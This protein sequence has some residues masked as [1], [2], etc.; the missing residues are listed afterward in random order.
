MIHNSQNY[1]FTLLKEKARLLKKSVKT[2]SGDIQEGLQK[3]YDALNE[4]LE[5]VEKPSFDPEFFHKD[6]PK[7]EVYN[8]NLKS[9]MDEIANLRSEVRE[10][11]DLELATFNSSLIAADSLLSEIS[12]LSSDIIDLRLT[13]NMELGEVIVG[14]DNFF[15]SSKIDDALPSA[16]T[17][18]QLIPGGGAIGLQRELVQSI[19]PESVKIELIER[20]RIIPGAG[21]EYEGL[22]YAPM[23]EQRPEGGS[24]HIR[25]FND[26]SQ[27]DKALKINTDNSID[28]EQGFKYVEVGANEDALRDERADLYDGES[29][30]FWEIEWAG[31]E[32]LERDYTIIKLPK[33]TARNVREAKQYLQ[34]LIGPFITETENDVREKIYKAKPDKKAVPIHNKGKLK[35]AITVNLSKDQPINTL[36]LN[37]MRFSSMA[38]IRIESIQF[39][40]TGSEQFSEVPDWDQLGT[41]KTLTKLSNSQ[42]TAAQEDALGDPGKASYRGTGA[43]SFPTIIGDKLRIIVSVDT[44]YPVRYQRKHVLLKNTVDTLEKKQ[45]KIG[46]H[47]STKRKK[48]SYEL[49]MVAK[50]SYI[51]TI[52]VELG[53]EPLESFASTDPISLKTGGESGGS[54]GGGLLGGFFGGA[55][56]GLFGSLFDFLGDIA[57]S[58]GLYSKTHEFEVNQTG[59]EPV[60]EWLQTYEDRARYAVGIRDINLGDYV[61]AD[62]SEFVSTV[63]SSPKEVSKVML[64]ADTFFPSSLRR[65]AANIKYYIKPE[66]N[67]YDIWH[68]INPSSAPTAYDEDGDVVPKII[69]FNIRSSESDSFEKRFIT[70]PEPVKAV[71]VKGMI[72]TTNNDFSPL[73]RSY[74]IIMWPKGGL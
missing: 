15:D 63:Y 16:S 17:L 26:S 43:F 4:F 45:K 22:Y 24:W 64:Y 19:P 7:S 10:V 62:A 52:L 55:I 57:A 40:T 23:G 1:T 12:K 37:P 32:T 53:I 21:R 74:K 41:D 36:N 73:I 39:G 68:R 35:V 58:L 8:N 54:L 60:K 3:V 20:P 61:Y 42:L 27:P 14:G 46:W 69:N 66:I 49:H 51:Q 9:L 33:N 47:T 13:N 29:N 6:S 50:L 11:E 28:L 70:T 48:R 67:N 25:L 65:G 5:S 59:F 18:A 34:A 2:S 56:G 38:P 30:T 71:R 31:A 44:A 72:H